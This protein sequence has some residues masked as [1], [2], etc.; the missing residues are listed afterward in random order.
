MQIDRAKTIE[1]MVTDRLINNTQRFH[2]FSLE[3]ES[4]GYCASL[5]S[6][7]GIS[8]VPSRD[9]TVIQFRSNAFKDNLLV[10]CKYRAIWEIEISFL[11]SFLADC[12]YLL[13]SSS[14]TIHRIKICMR[15]RI[16][17]F[18]Y[19]FY[20]FIYLLFKLERK[21]A[22]NSCNYFVQDQIELSQKLCK[23][24]KVK[25]ENIRRKKFLLRDRKR[26]RNTIVVF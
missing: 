11:P 20:L 13:V 25:K 16:S 6:L 12:P 22:Y 2:R 1:A 19:S 21:F 3:T 14:Y 4:D 9:S 26:G 10:K 7:V 5:E 17:A 8:R 23:E 24:E 15:I 18:K